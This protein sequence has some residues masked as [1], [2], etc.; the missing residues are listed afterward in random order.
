MRKCKCINTVPPSKGLRVRQDAND[1]HGMQIFNVNP[2]QC[3][4]HQFF[5]FSCSGQ[6]VVLYTVDNMEASFSVSIFSVMTNLSDPSLLLAAI[7]AFLSDSSLC[8]VC[9]SV[10]AMTCYLS[11]QMSISPAIRGASTAFTPLNSLS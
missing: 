3:F 4:G 11:M 8:F 2:S 6:S 7:A 9:V 5:S 1:L 10:L